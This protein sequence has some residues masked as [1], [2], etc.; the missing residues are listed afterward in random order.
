MDGQAPARLFP[1]AVRTN[2]R[3]YGSFLSEAHTQVV[4]RV[5]Y[6]RKD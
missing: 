6:K 4:L 5:A 2:I 1:G 3:M